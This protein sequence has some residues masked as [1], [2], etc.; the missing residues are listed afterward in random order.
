MSDL[1]AKK[2]TPIVIFCA[3]ILGCQSAVFQEDFTEPAMLAND[4]TLIINSCETSLD[5]GIQVCRVKEKSLIDKKLTILTPWFTNAYS[6]EINIRFQ[7]TVKSYSN[8]SSTFTLS[9]SGF[10]N[11]QTWSQDEDG[12]IQITVT[13]K[14]ENFVTR[15]LGYVYIIVLKE[16]YSPRPIF[17]KEDRGTICRINYNKTGR[18]SMS[19]IN[20]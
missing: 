12:L 9:W 13:T 15:A 14:G 8:E 18:S 10:F 17:K 11:K 19:C 4:K 20:D 3:L 2:F 6:S 16:T 7:D 5:Q 1:H